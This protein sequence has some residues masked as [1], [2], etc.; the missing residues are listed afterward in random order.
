MLFFCAVYD[1]VLM[2][3]SMLMFRILSRN[4]VHLSAVSEPAEKGSAP[5]DTA[6]RLKLGQSSEDC[7]GASAERSDLNLFYG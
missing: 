2:M 1:C 3:T 7:A 5:A 4:F 6:D